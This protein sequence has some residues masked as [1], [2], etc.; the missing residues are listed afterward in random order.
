MFYDGVIDEEYMESADRSMVEQALF[1]VTESLGAV[2]SFGPAGPAAPVLQTLGVYSMSYLDMKEQMSGPEFS[3]VSEE[4]K[5]LFSG[6]YGMTIGLLDKVGISKS[7]SKT[8]VGKKAIG[9]LLSKTFSSLPKKYTYEAF[10][11]ELKINTKMAISK[12]LFDAV[13]GG[14]VEAGTEGLQ[15]VAVIGLKK[16][17]NSMVEKEAFDTPQTWKE[18]WEQVS[19]DAVLGFIGGG[20]MN[21]TS[22]LLRS[23]SDQ[24]TKNS[25]KSIE[26]LITN[27]ELLD[28]YTKHIK[29]R[30]LTGEMTQQEAEAQVVA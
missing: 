20:I 5:V 14:A 21:G 25:I 8:P 2:L 15:A 13:G 22:T 17:Y 23:G 4:N 10:E 16:V 26:K 19:N 3:D 24:W 7:V 1:G 27:P 29:T 28:V 12:G 9:W 30:V 18:G 6:I 11:R